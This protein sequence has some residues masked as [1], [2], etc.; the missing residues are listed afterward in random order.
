M[1]QFKVQGWFPFPGYWFP[2]NCSIPP[3]KGARGMCLICGLL[4]TG[5]L[6]L[7]K[8]NQLCHLIRHCEE[9]RRSNLLIIILNGLLLLLKKQDR[10]DENLYFYPFSN[11]KFLFSN[12]FSQSNYSVLTIPY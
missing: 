6:F 1:K 10:N 2:V 5:Y 12:I 7:V 8:G 3:L 11:F 4:V 9:V